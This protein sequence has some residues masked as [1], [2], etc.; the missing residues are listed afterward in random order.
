MRFRIL[1]RTVAVAMAACSLT[2]VAA[3][4]IT[5][6]S[7]VT[8][9]FLDVTLSANVPGTIA[10]RHFNEGD[11]VKQGD[12]LISLDQRLEKLEV[13]RRKL[14][15]DSKVEV[16]AA[17]EQVKTLK[18]LLESTQKLYESTKSISREEVAK[19]ELEY[20]QAVAEYDRLMVV[21]DREQI[22]YEQ[23]LEQLRKRTLMAPMSGT[24]ARIFPQVGEDCKAQEPL[25][26]LVDV[27]QCYMVCNV[28]A[29]AGYRLKEGTTVKLEVEAGNSFVTVPGK[30]TY[31]SPV[32]DQASGLLRVKALFDNADGKV[33]PGVAGRMYFEEAA[34]AK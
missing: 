28:E 12:P 8:E 20:K 30:I 10:K 24:V 6:A 17:A 4:K 22:E 27:R 21:E 2:S 11:F 14:I 3:E 33:R 16:N 32:V 18:S 29:R 15:S 25:V 26:R 1:A 31:V 5:V 23:A 13:D 7:G 34:D 19:K 9:P